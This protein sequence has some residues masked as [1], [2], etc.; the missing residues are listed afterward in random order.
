MD[1]NLTKGDS[2]TP[3]W[4]NLID[5]AADMI[6]APILHENGWRQTSA[7]QPHFIFLK[8]ECRRWD[9]NPHGLNDHRHLK[10]ARLPIPP[11]LHIS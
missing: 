3:F 6:L 7:F 5:L 1:G 8:K 10:P 4:A 11:L 2:Q 9:L